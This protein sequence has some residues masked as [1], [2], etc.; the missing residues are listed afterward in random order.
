MQYCR[1]LSK[2]LNISA[3]RLSARVTDYK[4]A[5]GMNAASEA[6]AKAVRLYKKYRHTSIGE[7]EEM[8]ARY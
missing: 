3:E 8:A 2:E 5:A 6:P 7:L 4:T 1:E